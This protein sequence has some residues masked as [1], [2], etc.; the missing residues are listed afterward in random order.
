MSILN[1]LSSPV[2]LSISSILNRLLDIY[3]CTL[4][5]FLFSTKFFLKGCLEFC[6]LFLH[7]TIGP[8]T[9]GK[10][11]SVL[12]IIKTFT[13]KNCY[14]KY[15]FGPFPGIVVLVDLLTFVTCFSKRKIEH[16]KYDTR[17]MTKRR[18]DHNFVKTKLSYN[19]SRPSCHT[20]AP[21]EGKTRRPTTVTR[22][23][24]TPG[25][26]DHVPLRTK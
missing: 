9:A 22:L 11:R 15:G 25:R 26:L 13:F 5:N 7:E 8:E 10:S 2:D 4:F 19:S 21:K 1:I 20:T 14:N 6:F 12:E 18:S 24:D 3:S 17:I 23:T 16:K